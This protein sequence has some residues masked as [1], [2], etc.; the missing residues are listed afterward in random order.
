MS[1]IITGRTDTSISE[2]DINAI[3]VVNQW[4][5]T[6]GA[7]NNVPHAVY[8]MLM[9]RLFIFSFIVCSSVYFLLD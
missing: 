4:K 8:K 9:P 6:S 3:T 1:P 2:C 7:T 5:G